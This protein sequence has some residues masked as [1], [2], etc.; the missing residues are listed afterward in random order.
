LVVAAAVGKD[1]AVAFLE[2]LLTWLS[3]QLKEQV[4]RGNS[5]AG[6]DALIQETLAAHQRL[7]AN[8]NQQL[9]VESLLI[10][11]WRVGRAGK[12]A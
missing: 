1:D 9:V 11:W 12:A 3:A 10:L 6:I 5:A 4:K 8:A 2:W 7:R